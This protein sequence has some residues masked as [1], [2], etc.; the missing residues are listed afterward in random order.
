MKKIGC[1]IVDIYRIVTVISIGFTMWKLMRYW[2][3]VSAEGT[4][5][6]IDASIGA[7]AEKSKKPRVR[8]ENRPKQETM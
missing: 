8:E 4:V 3:S 6:A 1:C 5:H 2:H 7:A